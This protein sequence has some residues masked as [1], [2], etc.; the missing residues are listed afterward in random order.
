M[1]EYIALARAP[2]TEVGT[3]DSLGTGESLGTGKEGLSMEVM[4]VWRE[5]V[6]VVRMEGVKTGL[7]RFPTGVCNAETYRGLVTNTR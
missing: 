6:L 7:I 1:P 3:G 5:P 2:G 4:G